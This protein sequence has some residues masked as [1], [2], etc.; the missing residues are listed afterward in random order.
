MRT[1]TCTMPGP[2]STLRGMRRAE[3]FANALRVATLGESDACLEARGNAVLRATWAM[4]GT[5][6]RAGSP[7]LVRELQRLSEVVERVMFA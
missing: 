6:L 2:V 1:V 7:T 5:A 4:T 3:K